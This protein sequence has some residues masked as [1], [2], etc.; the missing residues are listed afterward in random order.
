MLMAEENVIVDLHRDPD[1]YQK[2]KLT[3]STGS[4]LPHAYFEFGG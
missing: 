1:H 4:P 2:S 3:T